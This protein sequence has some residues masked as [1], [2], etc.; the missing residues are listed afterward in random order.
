MRKEIEKTTAT[1]ERRRQEFRDVETEVCD[2]GTA[3]ME[4]ISEMIELFKKK[5]E[6]KMKLLQECF[7]TFYGQFGSE[8]EKIEAKVNQVNQ[9]KEL[10]IDSMDEE[11]LNKNLAL[12]FRVGNEGALRSALF[13]A[14]KAEQLVNLFRGMDLQKIIQEVIQDKEAL[15]EGAT[16]PSQVGSDQRSPWYPFNP[17]PWCRGSNQ[18]PGPMGPLMKLTLAQLAKHRGKSLILY[19]EIAL[20][21]VFKSFE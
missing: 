9:I 7:Q 1:L 13:R 18:T 2:A 16:G 6:K 10:N 8:M 11:E 20:A 3:W 12:L 21:I 5:A 14:T 19:G 17:P 15:E 4:N